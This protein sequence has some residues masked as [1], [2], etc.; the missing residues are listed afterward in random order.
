MSRAH[1]ATVAE[2]CAE[3]LPADVRK[4]LDRLGRATDVR[5]VAVMPDVHLSKEVCIGVAVAT[6]RRLYPAAVGDD[7]GCGMAALG[8][9]CEAGR[10]GEES[11]RTL[12][13]GLR[14]R[15]PT[16]RHP[17]RS[18]G[19]LPPEL[20]EHRLSQPS[21]ESEKKRT[22]AL[23]LGTLGRGNH[24]VE[25]QEDD[26]GALWLMVHSGSRSLGQSIRQCHERRARRDEGGLAWLDADDE[27]GRAYL[28]DLQWALSYAEANRRR[29]VDQVVALV[30]QHLDAQAAPGT[31]VTCTHNLVRRESIGDQELWVHR[32]GA[33]SARAGEPGIIPGSM[34]SP[35]F[36]VEGR[37]AAEALYSSSHGAG[38]ALSRSEAR[39]RISPRE[40]ERHMHGVWYDRRLAPRLRDEAPGAYK[41]IGAVMRAQRSLT[42]IVRRLRPLLCY[43]G[44]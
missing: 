15:V 22:A 32:K 43:K 7:I 35:S 26:Q 27:L 16:L 17:G 21:L 10:L 30:A 44:V 9:G 3:P 18:A 29:I 13:A 4:A 25:F 42:R 38:R 33:I 6:T 1:G 37:G 40:F 36:H 14:R 24:F 19:P 11:A 39:R 8:L 5:H 23:Q 12:L 34:G 41:D 28:D 20:E 2:F 31:L